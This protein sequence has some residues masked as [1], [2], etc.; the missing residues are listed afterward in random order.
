MND[1]PDPNQEP[2]D[3]PEP[4]TYTDEHIPKSL[5]EDTL[6]PVHPGE[7]LQEEFLQPLELTAADLAVR[8]HMQ[9]ESVE[10][11]A[12]SERPITTDDALRLARYFDTTPDFWLNLQA[13]HDLEV[14][15]ERISH[16]L[17]AITPHEDNSDT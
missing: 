3:S 14:T 16:E 10:S 5:T 1:F 12:R 6:P 8:L 4:E 11:L 15:R 13:Q 9:A 7:I 17:A 2:T